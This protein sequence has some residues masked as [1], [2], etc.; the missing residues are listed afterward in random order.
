MTDKINIPSAKY[1]ISFNQRCSCGNKGEDVIRIGTPLETCLTDDEYIEC[2]ADSITHEYIHHVLNHLFPYEVSFLFD[3]IADSVRLHKNL[4]LKMVRQ[5]NP[6]SE[7]WSDSIKK[8]GGIKELI[9]YYGLNN[10]EI[11]MILKEGI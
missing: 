4:L 1:E 10:Y 8:D 2:L 3:A 7:L 9:E 11:K 6:S 5:N